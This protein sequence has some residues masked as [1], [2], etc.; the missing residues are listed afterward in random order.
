MWLFLR[1]LNSWTELLSVSEK[2]CS[3]LCFR[4]SLYSFPFQR[5]P[6][7]LSVSE[8]TFS[9]GLY[10]FLFLRDSLYFFL[11]FQTTCTLVLY[12]SLFQRQHVLLDCAYFCFKDN[13]YFFL[14]HRQHLPVTVSETTSTPGLYLSLFQRQP[15][16]LQCTC[17]CFRDNLYSRTVLISISETTCTPGLYL[18]QHGRPGTTRGTES[19]TLS[20]QGRIQQIQ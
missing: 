13:L 2:T 10:F 18:W 9:P 1:H 8:T 4:D 5:Q 6:V 17:D 15:V 20:Y 16:L 12:L 19:T 11:L 3:P 7:L 14:F